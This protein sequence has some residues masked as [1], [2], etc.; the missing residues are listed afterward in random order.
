MPIVADDGS[1]Q[2]LAKIED[3]QCPDHLQKY[4][5]YCYTD[6]KPLCLR[7]TDTDMAAGL[8]L[9]V[10][11]EASEVAAPRQPNEE[12]H[13]KHFVKSISTVLE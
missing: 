12:T 9:V 7:C 13:S 5:L 4:R 10:D 6:D 1:G 2:P 8:G 11:G 3:S